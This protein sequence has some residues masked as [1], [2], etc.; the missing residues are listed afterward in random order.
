MYCSIAQIFASLS[1]SLAQDHSVKNIKAHDAEFLIC[2]LP[3][4][5]FAPI[6]ISLVQSFVRYEM[7]TEYSKI[8]KSHGMTQIELLVG[9]GSVPR[10]D[11]GMSETWEGAD[12]GLER[13]ISVNYIRLAA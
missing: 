2:S 4:Q 11:I 13:K 3:S 6:L 7:K 8:Q 10:R 5:A 12:M 9:W 1:H